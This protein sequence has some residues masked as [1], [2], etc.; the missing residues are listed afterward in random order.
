MGERRIRVILGDQRL[1]LVEDG[2]VLRSYRVSTSRYGAGER[3]GSLRTPLGRH[4]VRAMIGAGAPAGTVFRG[5]RKTGE[6]Y[7][8][9]LAS[10]QPGRDWVLSRILWLSGT[11][12]GKNRLGTVDS[13]RRYIY[14]HGTPERNALGTPASIGCIRMSDEDVIELYNMVSPGTVVDIE[15]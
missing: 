9:K 15:G 1:D 8:D 10:K 13:M 5:R 11:E 12:V 2:T 6:I 14:I 3:A 7:T 4:V